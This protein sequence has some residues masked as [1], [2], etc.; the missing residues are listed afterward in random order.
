MG[1][2]F[3]S[4]WIWKTVFIWLFIGDIVSSVENSPN[5]GDAC[6]TFWALKYNLLCFVLYHHW[7]SKKSNRQ[8]RIGLL[9][10]FENKKRLWKVCSFLAQSIYC[11]WQI[12]PVYFGDQDCKL[13]SFI[14]RYYMYSILTVFLCFGNYVPSCVSLTFN[15][16][17]YFILF[18]ADV[19]AF[20]Q[21]SPPTKHSTRHCYSQM[22][23]GT[24]SIKSNEHV[25]T[26]TSAWHSTRSGAFSTNASH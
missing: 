6:I 8:V 19:K 14:H 1:S 17:F 12:A 20:V 22:G 7:S 26:W 4:N 13:H 2:L 11:T 24:N 5:D 23:M 25:F 21:K 9:Q 10:K 3:P 16:F 18:F 15:L